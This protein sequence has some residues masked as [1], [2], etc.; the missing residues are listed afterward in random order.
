MRFLR[1]R[2][3]AGLVCIQ[4]DQ[5]I[6]RCLKKH[7]NRSAALFLLRGC[8]GGRAELEFLLFLHDVADNLVA[9]LFLLELGVDSSEL[10]R[11]VYEGLVDISAG[12]RA[13][14]EEFNAFLLAEG[15]YWGLLKLVFAIVLI[16]Q[17]VDLGVV[18]RVLL[19]LVVPEFLHIIESLLHGHVVGHEDAMG[20][21][22]VG[23]GDCAETLLTSGV[24]NL[25]FDDAVGDLDGPE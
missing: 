6:N 17:Q 13:Y 1:E 2:E 20:A 7:L 9:L 24:P 21:L 12:L 15:L 4:L 19:H 22:V 5:F 8:G 23:A 3:R 11:E 14:K 16:S 18:L 10:L 25:Q